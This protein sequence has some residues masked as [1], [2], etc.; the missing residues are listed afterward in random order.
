MCI[1]ITAATAE[2]ERI[3]IGLVH[4]NQYDGRR[5]GNTCDTSATNQHKGG[6]R[7]ARSSRRNRKE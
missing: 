4:H 2:S 5:G 3:I 7:D 1:T 6:R